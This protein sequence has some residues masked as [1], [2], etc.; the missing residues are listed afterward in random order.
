M[1]LPS[2]F[3]TLRFDEACKVADVIQ[4]AVIRHKA[5]HEIATALV[6]AG[7]F[8]EAFRVL[9]TQSLDEFLLMLT[10]WAPSFEWKAEHLSTT[11]FQ[12]AVKITE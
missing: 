3:W 2:V 5:V 10:E 4:N 7:R 12:E 6:K 11:V 1:T 8:T 9:E